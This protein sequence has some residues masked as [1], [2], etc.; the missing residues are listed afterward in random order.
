VPTTGDVV[1]KLQAAQLKICEA[2]ASTISL[3]M[4]SA[5]TRSQNQ[6]TLFTKIASEVEAFS[7]SSGKTVTGYGG[8]VNTINT[9]EATANSD[10]AA[11]KAAGPFSCTSTDPKGV[12]SNYQADLQ[13]ERADLTVLRTDVKNL[14]VAVAQANGASLSTSVKAQG[15]TTNE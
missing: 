3:I 15:S 5:N 8:L 11:L 2:R 7:L 12:V 10:L 4:N 9:A 14:I 1:D 13:K 6:I